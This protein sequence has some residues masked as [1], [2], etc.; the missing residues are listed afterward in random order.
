MSRKSPTFIAADGE[1]ISAAWGDNSQGSRRALEAG[2][3]PEWLS[4]VNS[5]DVINIKGGGRGGRLAVKELS[6]VSS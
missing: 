4:I 2:P 6:F 5:E 3:K 1:V